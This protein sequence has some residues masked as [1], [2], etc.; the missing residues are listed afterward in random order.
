VTDFIS[1]LYPGVVTHAR[2][3]P[4]AHRLRYRIFMLLLDLDE[5]PALDRSLKLF[6]LD[7]LRLTGFS[8]ADHLEGS[9]K[10]LRA[11]VEA[12]LASA[13]IVAGGAIRLL[14]MPRILGG[15]FNPLSVYFCH[16]PD[17][18][19][20]AILY[21]VNNTFGERHSYLIPVDSRDRRGAVR[22]GVDKA[23]YVSPFMDM[24]LT[25]AFHITPPGEHVSVAIDVRDEDGRV[26]VAA[27][28][29]LRQP[30]TD[31]NLWKAWLG[32]PWMTLGVMAAI[33]WEALKIWRKGEKIRTRPKAPPRP[34]TVAPAAKVMA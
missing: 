4:R 16:R 29:G 20:R 5:L 2:L 30:L 21:E 7:R 6:G 23:F 14:C 25:Y 1:G 28:A 9:G 10:T 24:D 34:V 17:G 13:G 12:H 3:R 18:A 22:H 31:A 33:H 19:L 11:Q 26:L 32:H 27:F 15:V 8:E